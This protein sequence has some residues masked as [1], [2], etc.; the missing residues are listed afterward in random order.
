[1]RRG[2]E[3]F[4]VLQAKLGEYHC[5]FLS[6]AQS[7]LVL[8]RANFPGGAAKLL[9]NWHS[10]IVK[11]NRDF[12]FCPNTNKF[13]LLGLLY[14]CYLYHFSDWYFCLPFI[15]FCVITQ[16][17]SH[18]DGIGWLS[19]LEEDKK[20]NVA[21]S[22]LYTISG[23]WDHVLYRCCIRV[24]FCS[25]LSLENRND[26]FLI[27]AKIDTENLI[28]ILWNLKHWAL[29]VIFLFA[30]N[31]KSEWAPGCTASDYLSVVLLCKPTYDPA[32]QYPTQFNH[33]FCC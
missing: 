17:I 7:S 9:R 8:F 25:E 16:L 13:F 12:R 21:K 19:Q 1:M 10:L 23:T 26:K 6:W 3:F 18:L 22:V 33:C 20:S 11:A 29:G 14:I 2:N 15:I 31:V 24:C 27:H 5:C 32:I 4:T 28:L 30:I